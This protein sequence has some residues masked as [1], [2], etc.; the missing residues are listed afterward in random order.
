MLS[1]RAQVEV[2]WHQ[3]QCSLVFDFA[4]V[5]AQNLH[6]TVEGSW[7]VVV[8]VVAAAEDILAD[9]ERTGLAVLG[10][11]VGYDGLAEGSVVGEGDWSMM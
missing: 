4:A 2:H 8:V 6:S 1:R 7:V 5:A 11:F 3:G 9:A 10:C